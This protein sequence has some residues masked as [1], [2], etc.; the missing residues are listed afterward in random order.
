[1]KD[2]ALLLLLYAALP[3]HPAARRLWVEIARRLL[4]R[5]AVIKL[6]LTPEPQ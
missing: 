3:P 5:G 4:A 1:M 6:L 2:K